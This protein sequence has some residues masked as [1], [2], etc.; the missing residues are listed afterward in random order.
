MLKCGSMKNEVLG[1]GSLIAT[2]LNVKM[3][4]YE[5]LSFGEWF[6]NFYSPPILEGKTSFRHFFSPLI[7][8]I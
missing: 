6:F 3:W 1:S 4:V 5:K 8:F 7:C 2:P